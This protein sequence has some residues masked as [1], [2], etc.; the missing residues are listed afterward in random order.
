[1]VFTKQKIIFSLCLCLGIFIAAPTVVYARGLVPCG[2]YEANGTR[3]EPCDVEDIFVL[4]ARVTNFL[5]AMAGVVAVYYIIGGGFWLIVSTGNEE[6][7][8][9]RKNQISNAVIGFVL[10]MMAYM[11][12]NTVVNYMLT[13]SLVTEKNAACRFDLTSPLTYP[14]IDPQKCSNHPDPNMH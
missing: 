4:I 13:R 5:I 12:V 9:Q 14:T 2:G 1:M 8:T 10:V 6:A 3:E 11:F 7:I